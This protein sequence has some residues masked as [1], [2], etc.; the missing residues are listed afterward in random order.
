[1]SRPEDKELGDVEFLGWILLSKLKNQIGGQISRSKFLKLACIADRR[2]KEE[3]EV[4]LGLPRYWYMYGELANQH[5][6][7]GEFY[8]APTAIG[9]EGQQYIPKNLKMEDFNVEDEVIMKV[10]PIVESVISDFGDENVDSIKRHQYTEFAEKEFIREY[11]EFRWVLE[12]IDLGEQIR[13]EYFK[14]GQS[15]EEYVRHLLDN[16][17]ET[18]PTEESGFEEVRPLYLKWDDTVRLMLDQSVEYS[19]IAEFLDRFIEVLSK[20]VLRLKYNQSIS[21]KR[22][23]RWEEEGEDEL[24]QFRKDI[25]DE[26]R[27]LFESRSRGTELDSVS[28]SYSNKIADKIDKILAAE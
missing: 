16:M 26:R 28:E 3:K 27:T 13:L 21:S 19:K 18:Y 9:W 8:N 4:D 14:N 15:N 10:I 1:M 5:E 22:L 11:G 20:S 25:Q 23:E 24:V 2:L 6:F 12:N 7:S 17:I